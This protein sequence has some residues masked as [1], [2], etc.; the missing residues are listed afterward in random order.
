MLC[1]FDAESIKDAILELINDKDKRKK[2]G[3]AA[4]NRKLIYE[5]DLGMIYELMDDEEV[6]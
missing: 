5:E 4:S 2:F 6:K 3:I 1:Q